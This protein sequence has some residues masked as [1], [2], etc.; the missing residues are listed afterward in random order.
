[1]G[2]LVWSGAHDVADIDAEHLAATADV[3]GVEKDALAG[4]I[5]A[6]VQVA[7]PFAFE[8]L[9]LVESA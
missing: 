6:G 2:M 1:M 5:T 3:G 7:T 4:L 8:F 9:G